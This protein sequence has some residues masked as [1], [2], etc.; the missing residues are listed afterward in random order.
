MTQLVRFSDDVIKGRWARIKMADGMPCY[1]AIGPR[2]IVIKKS[3]SGIIGSRLYEIRHLPTIEVMADEL[4]HKF[5][6]VLTPKGMTNSTLRPVVNAILHHE[7]L[8][9][10]TLFFK[11]LE[12][13][14][15]LV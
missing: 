4:K 1:V 8:D 6:N 12:S 2:S 11:S 7:A 9:E 5:Q 3:K 13:D 10:V 14:V 15:V